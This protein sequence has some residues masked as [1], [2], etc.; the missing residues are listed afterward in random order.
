MVVRVAEP[1]TLPKLLVGRDLPTTERKWQT[2]DNRW[3]GLMGMMA[4]VSDDCGSAK[5]K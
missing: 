2:T 3:L 5:Q 4:R 1:P